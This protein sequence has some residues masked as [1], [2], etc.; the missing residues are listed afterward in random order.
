MWKWYPLWCQLVLC[1]L[2]RGRTGY[3]FVHVIV[4]GEREVFDSLTIFD[5]LVL[6]VV[7]VTDL[8]R[9]P[10]EGNAEV[11]GHRFRA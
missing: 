5:T 10:R 6:T 8:D 1:Y 11:S 4:V 9:Q 2:I 7:G 3:Q